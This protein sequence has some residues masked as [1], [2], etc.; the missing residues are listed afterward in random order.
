MATQQIVVSSANPV[1]FIKR[2]VEL[3]QQ[4]AV[5]K[6]NTC[7]RL[8]TLPFIAE[9]TFEVNGSEELKV[10]PGVNAIPVPLGEKVY[11]KEQ[12][13]AMPI[14]EMRIIV[15][16]RGVKGRDKS[17]MVKQY[18]AAVESGKNA[19]ESSEEDE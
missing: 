11:T 6:D 14:E 16:S 7:P 10:S 13:E 4:G 17:K 8:K 2:V 3:A 18:L 1:E 19:D 12:L 9:F 5:L 15:A